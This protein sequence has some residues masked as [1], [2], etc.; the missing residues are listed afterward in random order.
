M[1]DVNIVL[2]CFS[3]EVGGLIVLAHLTYDMWL[4]QES[5]GPMLK[6]SIIKSFSDTIYASFQ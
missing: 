6:I 5:S 4:F 2:D 3:F 1:K